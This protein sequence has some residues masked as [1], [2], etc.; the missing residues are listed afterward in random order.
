MEKKKD[1]MPD[2][3]AIPIIGVGLAIWYASES[4]ENYQ[5]VMTWVNVAADIIRWATTPQA[6]IPTQAVAPAIVA[7]GLSAIGQIGFLIG[8]LMVAFAAI[9]VF[10]GK[11]SG[12]KKDA[13]MQAGEGPTK[14][15]PAFKPY[16]L[17]TGRNGA[18]KV[19]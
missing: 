6:D 10:S 14:A 17:V 3:L 5:Q 7:T 18:R 16:R 19:E 13:T 9:A 2:W 15:K 1:E 11:L 12:G 4:P 8:I